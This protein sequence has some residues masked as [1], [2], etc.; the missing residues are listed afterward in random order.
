MYFEYFHNKESK[1]YLMQIDVFMHSNIC[2]TR[3]SN[4]QIEVVVQCIFAAPYRK[5]GEIIYT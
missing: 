5:G 2:A 4:S 1:I 3:K